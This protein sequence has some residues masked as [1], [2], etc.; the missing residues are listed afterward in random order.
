MLL[1]PC[2]ACHDGLYSQ[3]VNQNKAFLR[4]VAFVTAI[5]QE[6]QKEAD[7]PLEPPEE[8]SLWADRGL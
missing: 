6:I 2:L 4:E 5:R 7:P 1:L 8:P 3:T